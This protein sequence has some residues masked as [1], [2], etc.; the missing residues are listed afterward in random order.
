[1]NTKF[2]KHKISQ[3]FF[4]LEVKESQAVRTADS[5]SDRE[6]CDSTGNMI[7]AQIGL[8]S[9]LAITKNALTEAFSLACLEI[10][11]RNE[12]AINSTWNRI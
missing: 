5:Q 4:L 3:E 1:M 10:R 7:T 2:K 8:H 9:I 6:F 12:E 11:S